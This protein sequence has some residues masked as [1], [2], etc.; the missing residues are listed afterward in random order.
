[1]GG[2]TRRKQNFVPFQM[3]PLWSGLSCRL[4]LVLSGP[5]ARGGVEASGLLG[6]NEVAVACPCAAA[7][8]LVTLG[9]RA[10]VLRPSPLGC[11]ALLL[12]T[13]APSSRLLPRLS[14]ARPMPFLSA[15]VPPARL[16]PRALWQSEARC[17]RRADQAPGVYSMMEA[18][19]R[20]R[21]ERHVYLVL[22]MLLAHIAGANA[23]SC[24]EFASADSDGSYWCERAGGIP[25]R[26]PPHPLAPA[27]AFLFAEKK[28]RAL[29]RL[30]VRRPRVVVV[31]ARCRDSFVYEEMVPSPRCT[32]LS[33][34]RR[35]GAD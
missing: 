4:L 26:G 1:M 2:V 15:H 24:A 32:A 23:A 27:A 28:R 20:R 34:V 22:A 6:S 10:P 11:R 25:Q 8:R 7:A 31:A 29:A 14:H 17:Y 5:V 16:L 12:S 30:R 35:C 33:R 9:V 19:W 3:T 13:N 21:P 18:A